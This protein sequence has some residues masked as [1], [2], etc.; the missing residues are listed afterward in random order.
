[1]IFLLPFPLDHSTY[2]LTII[3]NEGC[4]GCK[5]E[6]TILQTSHNLT[7][8]FPPDVRQQQQQSNKPFNLLSSTFSNALVFVM[9]GLY[10]I[11]SHYHCIH[12][13]P[14][15]IS[16]HLSYYHTGCLQNLS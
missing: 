9:C 14:Q 2:S 15:T 5:L 8:S 12:H 7:L 16:L 10:P 1:M 6:E 4:M 13:Q 3:K 11:I